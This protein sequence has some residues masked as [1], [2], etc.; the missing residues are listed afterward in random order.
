MLKRKKLDGKF[1]KEV[2]RFVKNGLERENLGAF[3]LF[4]EIVA[5]LVAKD[6]LMPFEI[7]E[8][9]IEKEEL[10]KDSIELYASFH[11]SIIIIRSRRL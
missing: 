10:V 1:L 6:T 5:L 2:D 9:F 7:Y 4:Y 3:E 11:N 8:K